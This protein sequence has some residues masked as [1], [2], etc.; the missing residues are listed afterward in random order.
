MHINLRRDLWKFWLIG[1]SIVSIAFGYALHVKHLWGP[2]SLIGEKVFLDLPAQTFALVAILVGAFMHLR[3]NK[4]RSPWFVLFAA[5][6]VGSYG[7]GE[8][9]VNYQSV[10]GSPLPFPSASTWLDVAFYLLFAL[11]LLMLDHRRN[12]KRSLTGAIDGSVIA[13]LCVLA[14]FLLAPEPPGGGTTLGLIFPAL[15]L[16]M[17]GAM[18]RLIIGKPYIDPA[19]VML[20]LSVILYSVGDTLSGFLELQK[21]EIPFNFGDQLYSFAAIFLG[22]AALHP[23]MVFLGRRQRGEGPAAVHVPERR[24][25]VT[26]LYES[27]EKLRSVSVEPVVLAVT[28]VAPMILYAAVLRI[29]IPWAYALAIASMVLFTHE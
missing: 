15:D 16:F 3:T 17:L 13:L 8:I 27:P 14:T 7:Q 11:G 21:A 23:S 28:I 2:H 26:V 22:A 24:H 19:L 12:P 18:A 25:R 10:F 5:L 1:A 4:E 20:A 29:W 6:F 9:A